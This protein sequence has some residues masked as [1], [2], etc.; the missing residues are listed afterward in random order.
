MRGRLAGV[1]IFAVEAR[2][3]GISPNSPPTITPV[4]H[5]DFLMLNFLLAMIATASGATI[6]GV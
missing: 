6:P 2:M 5:C 1:A 4:Y 3:A